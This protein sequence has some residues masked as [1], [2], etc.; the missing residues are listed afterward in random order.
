MT[1]AG[2]LAQECK[3]VLRQPDRADLLS[4]P[5]SVAEPRAIC[6]IARMEEPLA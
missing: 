3:A 2:L 4:Q 1:S 6:R 5:C